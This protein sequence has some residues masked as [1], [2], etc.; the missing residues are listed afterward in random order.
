MKIPFQIK[1][2]KEKK[3]NRTSCNIFRIK[4]PVGEK[5]KDGLFVRDILG[6]FANV[7]KSTRVGKK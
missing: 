1:K 4:I 3:E 2:K 5:P 7:N 6:K